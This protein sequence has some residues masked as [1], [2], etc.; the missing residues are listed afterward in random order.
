MRNK[1]S[2]EDLKG[3]G[4]GGEEAWEAKGFDFEGIYVDPIV[5]L[6]RVISASCKG[7]RTPRYCEARQSRKVA[8]RGS[9]SIPLREPSEGA[10]M[11]ANMLLYSTI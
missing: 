5:G 8:Q 6:P 9:N 3:A 4:V 2:H 10:F 1:D 7:Q 11:H